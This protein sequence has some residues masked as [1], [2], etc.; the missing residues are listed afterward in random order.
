MGQDREPRQTSSEEHNFTKKA[1]Y[2]GTGKA[3]AS[4]FHDI[5]SRPRNQRVGQQKPSSGAVEQLRD[6]S[7]AQGAEDGK[8]QSAFAQIKHKCRKTAAAAQQQTNQ[9]HSEIL[10]RQWHRSE[11]Q[12]DC[13][14][15]TQCYEYAAAND[16]GDLPRRLRDGIVFL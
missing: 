11:W 4:M 13:N 6:S 12:G 8:S 1:T 5:P 9:Q 7:W 16:K 3:F 2:R 14:V 10:H 15:S